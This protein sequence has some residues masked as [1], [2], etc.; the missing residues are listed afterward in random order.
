MK[1]IVSTLLVCSA[2]LVAA[3]DTWGGSYALGPAKTNI[4]EMTTTLT[5][6][7]A[8]PTQA[9]KLF[10]WPG[11]SN[12]TGELIQTT[13]E[14]WPD[15]S[16]CG[17]KKR[18]W[19]VRASVFGSFGQRDGNAAVVKV[20]DSVT[21]HYKLGPNKL[22]WT[23]NVLINRKVVSTLQSN[24]GPYMKGWGTGT[25][26]NDGCTGTTSPQKYTNT[27]ITLDAADPKFGS[28][29]ASARGA[30]ATGLTSEQGGKVWKIATINVPK[31]G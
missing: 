7:A 8:P 12:G 15:N 10:L 20:T 17:A 28:T 29:A 9:G 31:M 18:E 5:P 30:T 1:A 11:I 4:I 19:C 22:T 25:E 3:V 13:L 23:Q 16:W 14:H 24:S 6:G 21:I 27:V 26:C 2:Y